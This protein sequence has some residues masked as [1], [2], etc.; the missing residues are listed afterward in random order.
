MARSE[1]SKTTTDSFRIDVIAAYEHSTLRPDPREANIQRK[2]TLKMYGRTARA[3]VHTIRARHSFPLLPDCVP[4][5][6]GVFVQFDRN[7]F[8]L[9]RS[10][11]ASLREP[12]ELQLWCS[13][14]DV[15]QGDV[16]LNHLR[17]GHGAGVRKSDGDVHFEV[18]AFRYGERSHEEM[19]EIEGCVR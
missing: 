13:K 18:G 11:V 3:N 7:G 4:P 6:Y 19:G 14:A 16:H 17:T 15:W 2:L 10:D 8:A 1:L 9:A 5:R 12:T